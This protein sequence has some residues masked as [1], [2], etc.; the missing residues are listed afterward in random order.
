MGKS[1]SPI[2]IINT[3]DAL[4]ANSQTTLKV[5]KALGRLE[6]H[7]EQQS[8][9][10]EV[11]Q[12]YPHQLP[13]MAKFMTESKEWIDSGYKQGKIPERYTKEAIF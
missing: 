3:D 13:I 5:N 4:S 11:I 8:G 6:I 1:R 7:H 9:H 10:V 2:C 12:V